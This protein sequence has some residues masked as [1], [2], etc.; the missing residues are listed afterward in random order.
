[1]TVDRAINLLVTV[2][3]VEMMVA[4]GLGV[5]PGD[6]ARVVRDWRLVARAAAANYVVVPAFTVGLLFL[7]AAP[8]RVAAGFLV[9]PV[10]PGAPY[11]PPLTAVAKGDVTT[12]I[13]LMSVLAG[14]S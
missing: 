11:G 6:V 9:L 14:S 3:L 7:F 8:A 10:C 2:T 4:I 13:G 1:M 12:A 5:T